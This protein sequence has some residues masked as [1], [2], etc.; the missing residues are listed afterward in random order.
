MDDEAWACSQ[1][2]GSLRYA[3]F[4][5]VHREN[6]QNE[7]SLHQPCVWFGDRHP[8]LILMWLVSRACF[9]ANRARTKTPCIT[10]PWSVAPVLETADGL[11]AVLKLGRRL[12]TGRFVM[13]SQAPNTTLSLQR[14]RRG[15]CRYLLCD[16]STG[17]ASMR[18][19]MAT[20]TVNKLPGSRKSRHRYGAKV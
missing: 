19:A 11:G 6:G 20:E 17:T 18:A 14:P 7:V 9:K 12:R 10:R 2:Q 16:R 13:S 3:P 8:L 15:T 1:L 5:P 4:C